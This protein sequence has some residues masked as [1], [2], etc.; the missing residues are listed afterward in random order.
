M[1]IYR[2]YP[3][4]DTF[5]FTESANGNAGS[6]EILEI[7][8]Y[9]VAD[10]LQTSRILM[11]FETQE[12]KDT[13]NSKIGSTAF[14][15]SLHLNFATAYELLSSFSVYVHPL[16]DSW[17]KGV[18]KYDDSPTNNSGASWNYKNTANTSSW[19]L[20]FS[21]G[22]LPPYVT[23][24]YSGIYPGGASWYTGSNG[25]LFNDNFTFSGSNYDIN[26]GVTPIVCMFYS[27]SLANNGFIIKI[28]DSL[29]KDTS[30]TFRLKYYGKN[31]NT[32]YT[33]Y[34]EFKWDD[35]VYS[36]SLSDLSTDKII[37]S[38]SNNKNVFRLDDK[39]R[40]K[41]SAK[42]EFPIRTFTTSS[43]YLQE[44]KLPSGSCWGIKDEYT[45]EMVIPFDSSFTKVSTDNTGNYFD[46]YM[47]TL[48]PE[49]YYR[50]LVKT[51]IGGSSII[52][53][54]KIIF[55]VISNG[56]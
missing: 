3:E 52:L 34:L 36:S 32:I 51:I 40:F 53:D 6:D 19:T 45:G 43:I 15:A 18:G 20:P 1:T 26:I 24:S 35:S 46:L 13:I 33:P 48:R 47:N 12:I 16:Y 31:T 5:I 23:S 8:S 44:Y 2:I 10:V 50:V 7:G 37:I 9:S 4:K 17:I 25:I 29:E 27:E 28:Q 49:R 55:K 38:T 54:D 30:S 21:P 39:K 11:R 42:P 41:L 22:G 14:T 56:Y